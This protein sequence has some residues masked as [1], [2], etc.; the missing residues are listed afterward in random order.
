MIILSAV[1]AYKMAGHMNQDISKERFRLTKI[2]KELKDSDYEY[3]SQSGAN[4]YQDLC[5]KCHGSNFSA[6]G[7]TLNSDPIIKNKIYLLKTVLYGIQTSNGTMPAFKKIKE[8]D[9]ADLLNYLRVKQNTDNELI[10]DLDVVMA[11]IDYIDKKGPYKKSD[12]NLVK[13]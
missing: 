13:P 10:T 9:L 6:Y 1:T 8:Q 11:K 3:N 5:L 7:N 2:Y 12:F 4:L